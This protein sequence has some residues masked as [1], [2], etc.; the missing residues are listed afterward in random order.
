M[1]TNNFIN[2]WTLNVQHPYVTE[3]C[4]VEIRKATKKEI[5]QRAKKLD[6]NHTSV[7][8]SLFGDLYLMRTYVYVNDRYSSSFV[9]VFNGKVCEIISAEE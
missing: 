7:N 5:L 2:F 1:K 8:Q 4:K 3:N 9:R 6:L